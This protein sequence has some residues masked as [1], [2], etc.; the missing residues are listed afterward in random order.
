MCFLHMMV[1]SMCFFI[2]CVTKTAVRRVG[3]PTLM[4]DAIHAQLTMRKG[5]KAKANTTATK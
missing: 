2:M 1:A 4:N 3:L 5:N